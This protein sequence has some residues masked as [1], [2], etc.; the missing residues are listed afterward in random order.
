MTLWPHLATRVLRCGN[1]HIE[2][3]L[4]GRVRIRAAPVGN[5]TRIPTAHDNVSI[6][7]EYCI[8]W[9]RAEGPQDA[10]YVDGGHNLPRTHAIQT[11]SLQRAFIRPRLMSPCS[12][13]SHTICMHS[14]VHT[15]IHSCTLIHARQKVHTHNVWRETRNAT[16]NT[17]VQR[18]EMITPVD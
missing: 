8:V 6:F 5:V 3:S 15:Y 12:V 2:G 4:T 13:Q 18:W 10:R 14:C 11:H 16:S 1:P 9:V 17:W 7:Q